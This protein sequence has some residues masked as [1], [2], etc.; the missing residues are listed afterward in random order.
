[1][2]IT[3]HILGEDHPDTL[4]SLNNLGLL[5]KDKGEF[6]KAEI[7][8]RKALEGARRVLGEG[9]SQY[10]ELTQRPGF[11]SARKGET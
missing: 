3:H 9:P 1:M 4:R 11:A 8:L 7:L 6:D 10:T 5:L 2:K